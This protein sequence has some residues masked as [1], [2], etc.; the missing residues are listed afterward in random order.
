MSKAEAIHARKA[1][2]RTLTEL[3]RR[4]DALVEIEQALVL[5]EGDDRET[6]W[7]LNRKGDLLAALDRQH[8]ALDVWEQAAKVAGGEGPTG[9]VGA[10]G[11]TGTTGA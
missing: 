10:T 5:A 7:L 11:T 9:P 6:A 4:D 3:G 1:R 2:A 8:E